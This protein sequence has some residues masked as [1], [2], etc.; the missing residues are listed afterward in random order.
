MLFS[1]AN[2]TEGFERFCGE[3]NVACTP[4]APMTPAECDQKKTALWYATLVWSLGGYHHQVHGQDG[5]WVARCRMDFDFF[6]MLKKVTF[7]GGTTQ[8][9]KGHKF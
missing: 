2:R 5:G 1:A 6:N 7:S 9:E 8:F 3:E 4:L